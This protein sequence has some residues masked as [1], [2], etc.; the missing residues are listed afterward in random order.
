MI[1]TY[2]KAVEIINTIGKFRNLYI[3]DIDE[4]TLIDRYKA[5]EGITEEITEDQKAAFNETLDK[6]KKLLEDIKKLSNDIINLKYGTSL[7][8]TINIVKDDIG[9]NFI[10]IKHEYDISIE[11]TL[12]LFAARNKL[13]Y[14]N[15]PKLIY[16]HFYENY[17]SMCLN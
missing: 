15:V 12:K 13:L 14:I 11:K 5:K 10:I 3:I 6:P 4:K 16:E 17:I 2:E 1:D 7:E 9:Y 8:N